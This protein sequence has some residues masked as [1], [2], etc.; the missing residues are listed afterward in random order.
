MNEQM[1]SIRARC[2]ALGWVFWLNGEGIAFSIQPESVSICIR[3]D[4]KG[5]A[6][7]ERLLELHEGKFEIDRGEYEVTLGM[8][9]PHGFTSHID[10]KTLKR[11]TYR[12]VKW[13]G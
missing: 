8:R 10:F 12:I 4:N 13:E 1:E 5:F 3:A 11:G 9:I 2:D 6:F 7:V